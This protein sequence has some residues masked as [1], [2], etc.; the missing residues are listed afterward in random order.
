MRW[1]NEKMRA[2]I[3]VIAYGS[4]GIMCILVL[5]AAVIS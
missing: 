1:S 4:F 3:C 2:W 5:V